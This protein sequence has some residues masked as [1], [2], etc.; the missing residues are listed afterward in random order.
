MSH[1]IYLLV[2]PGKNDIENGKFV[3][4]NICNTG[5]KILEHKGYR[6][7]DV[8]RLDDASFSLIKSERERIIIRF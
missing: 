5:F 7:Y 2:P 4:Y 3:W 1:T 8:N 6:V